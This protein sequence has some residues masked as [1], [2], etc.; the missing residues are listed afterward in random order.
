M[1]RYCFLLILVFTGNLIAQPRAPITWEPLEM[2]MQGPADTPQNSP[3]PFGVYAKGDT[4][5]LV[6][7]KNYVTHGGTLYTGALIRIS[8]NDGQTW[9]PWMFV[10]DTTSHSNVLYVTSTSQGIFGSQWWNGGLGQG[11]LFRTT[12][13][14]Q[15]W[16]LPQIFMNGYLYLQDT[17]HDTII[18]NGSNWS[19]T[20][21]GGQSY[22]TFYPIFTNT[23]D[24]QYLG[25]GEPHINATQSWA[26]ASCTG[27]SNEM[28]RN[29][30]LFQRHSYDNLNNGQ[31]LILTYGIDNFFGDAVARFD[32]NGNGVFIVQADTNASLDGLG[33]LYRYISHDYGNSWSPRDTVQP[34][35]SV[36]YCPFTIQLR[37]SSKLW[38]V[39]WE[40]SSRDSP[41]NLAPYV[42]SVRVSISG[43]RCFNW[44]PQMEAAVFDSGNPIYGGP[45][46]LFTSLEGNR[47]RLFGSASRWNH[48]DG[49]YFWRVE[50]T[51][52]PDTIPPIIDS[53]VTFPATMHG[54]STYTL[55]L[56]AFETDTI[57][58]AVAKVY[59]VLKRI[60]QTDSLQIPL[61]RIV[62]GEYS[63]DFYLR[64][65]NA[66]YLYY[67]VAEDMWENRSYY[68]DSA[69]TNPPHFWVG[70]V[71]AVKEQAILPQEPYLKAFPNPANG[72]ITFTGRITATHNPIKLHIYNLTGALVATVDVHPT[73]TG[74]YR[75]VWDC[76]N[77]SG[78]PVASGVYFAQLK[79]Q[80]RMSVLPE[81]KLVRFT[82]LR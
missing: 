77:S 40:D 46:L 53:A 14:G 13:L 54:D 35:K 21:N 29:V 47:I 58:D 79:G 17:Y 74:N 8:S 52:H 3:G 16:S 23:G 34:I 71:I 24:V 63:Q 2:F 68:P 50:G 15:T 25:L 42:A 48:V 65:D 30:A 44:Y 41:H 39:S 10:A 5:C 26:F 33:I 45:I 51:I 19:W 36:V 28:Q 64:S 61:D 62:H 4:I 43:N 9:T 12:N 18:G 78:K 27:H 73:I 38:A 60:G 55:S 7:Q 81:N 22:S 72:M 11:G 1:I 75:T 82:I 69:R 32:D 57:F 66:E 76:R 49:Y 20:S 67:Y 6:F 70:P 80:T 31:P 59:F 37:Q 56:T